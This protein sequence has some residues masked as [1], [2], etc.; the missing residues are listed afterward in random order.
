[1]FPPPSAPVAARLARDAALVRQIWTLAWPA[2][3]HTLLLTAVFVVGRLMIGRYSAT[4]LA[5]MQ[6]AGTLTWS[7]YS[8]LT[9][10]SA[11]VLAIVARSVGASD[12]LA[13]ARAARAS[14]IFAFALGVLAALFIWAFERPLLHLLFPRAGDAVLGQAGDYLSVVAWSLPLGFV[15]T[16]AAVSLQAAGD[17]RSPLL[18]GTLGNVV[19]IGLA[20]L[21]IFGHFGL[22]ALGIRGAA[23]GV[24][25]TM[26]I[27]GLLL[28]GVLL[29]DSSPLP[30][31]AA[32]GGGLLADLRRVLAVSVPAFGEK[33]AYHAG[34][35]LYV[36]IIALLGEI[37][38]A[39]N[40]AVISIEA[41]SWL[42]ADGFGIA[43]GALV[44]Q[45]LGARQR[46]DASRAGL[47]AAMMAVFSLSLVGVVFAA[48]SGALVGAFSSDEAILA[49]GAPAIRVAAFAQPF[50][51]FAVVIGMALRG[52]GDTRTVLWAMLLGS[53]LVRPGVT[54]LCA[55]DLHLGLVGVWLGSTADWICR[56]AVLGWAFRR[57]R[58]RE[59]GV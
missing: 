10:F 1:M 7:L 27:E 5:S 46:D 21:L 54:W 17:T 30:L 58:W 55:I 47:L 26:A 18:A 16:I 11:G 57:G 51:G 15:E 49:A 12:P 25:A 38:M 3:T 35:M 44:G 48:A 9:A 59:V 24:A 34:Y 36:S 14:L 2:I 20:A 29:S 40:Q 45:K 42:S 23:I 39:A 13:A 43:A 28:T 32:P 6:I 33:V 19:N 31:R 8:V 53:L 56:A 22:P 4:A 37:A 41:I 50:M 52:A